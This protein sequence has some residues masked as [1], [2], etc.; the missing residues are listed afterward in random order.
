MDILTAVVTV[1]VI[2]CTLANLFLTYMT[3]RKKK[4]TT[5]TE[6]DILSVIDSKE[7]NI[8]ETLHALSMERERIK[9]NDTEDYDA[10]LTPIL[11]S[12]EKQTKPLSSEQWKEIEEYADK[13]YDNFTNR[14]RYYYDL[15][16]FEYKLS[17]LI[18]LGIKP[19]TIA[20][21]TAHSKQSV[22]TT[23]SR[24]Y[25]KVFQKHGTGKD[26]DNF[27]KAL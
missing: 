4:Y 1:I 3:W 26:W 27:I 23:R 17:L 5:D 22:T 24:L 13:H 14:V 8:Y 6:K 11:L 9:N 12:I 7:K 21:L 18:K 16:D 19:A 15:N 25:E 10:I 2:S 20:D